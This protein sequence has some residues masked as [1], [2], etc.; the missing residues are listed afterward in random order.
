MITFIK[1]KSMA[2]VKITG[3]AFICSQMV[4]Y[5]L[6]ILNKVYAIKESFINSM[7]LSE[8]VVL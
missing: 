7:A 8:N 3:K 2:M 1:A 6:A 4:Q 5:S